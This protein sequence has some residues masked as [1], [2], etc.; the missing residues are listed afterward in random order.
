MRNIKELL[1]LVCDYIKGSGVKDGET[2][3]MYSQALCSLTIRL[4]NDFIISSSERSF[5]KSFL[6]KEIRKECYK[7]YPLTYCEL[8]YGKQSSGFFFE[9]RNWS[10]RTQWLEEIISKL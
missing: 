7:S 10:I 5:I 1:Q 4:E 6:E 8:D 3:G 9:K 2:I